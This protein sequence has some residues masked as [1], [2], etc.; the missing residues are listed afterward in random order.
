MVLEA[1]GEN[2][3]PVIR[4]MNL[5]EPL[6]L[7]LNFATRAAATQLASLACDKEEVEVVVESVTELPSGVRANVGEVHWRM[8]VG[9]GLPLQSL[10]VSVF[11]GGRW[12]LV[13]ITTLRPDSTDGF[14]E[15]LK[16]LAFSL[17]MDAPEQ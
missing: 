11:H 17:S 7:P 16:A 13:N 4:V 10:F 14:P 12:V 8:D 15:E 6:W 2:R 1:R 9:S 5:N 3:L